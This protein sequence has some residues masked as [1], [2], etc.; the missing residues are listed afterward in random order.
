MITFLLGRYWKRID[1]TY[2]TKLTHSPLKWFCVPCIFG[3]YLRF[4][5]KEAFKPSGIILFCGSQGSG[6]TISMTRY[7]YN[8]KKQYPKAILQT[9]YIHD[10]LKSWRDLL[11]I[12]NGEK[13]II[14][15]IDE[16]GLW[17]NSK[18]SK[19][20]DVA[21]LQIVAQNRKNRRVICG[22]CQQ[23]YQ[24][25]KDIRC[26][27]SWLCDCY[28]VFGFITINKWNKP[29]FD[30]DGNIIKSR[31]KKVDFFIQSPGLRNAYDTWKT[32]TAL[33]KDGYIRKDLMQQNDN[34][35]DN[36]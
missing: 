20:F 8:L 19:D 28:T 9:N 10:D 33:S 14:T 24:I 22:S 30:A 27:V 2:I 5:D 32:I 23:F 29:T 12:Y 6:K 36:A 34:A 15:A 18:N 13:G 4:V 3:Y 21:L 35:C 17:C 11:K 1:D 26:Q 25:A 7:I 31:V 16:L